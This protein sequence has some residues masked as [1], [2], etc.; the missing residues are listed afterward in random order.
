MLI[1]MQTVRL[2]SLDLRQVNVVAEKVEKGQWYAYF[3]IQNLLFLRTIGSFRGEGLVGE[4][5][6]LKGRKLILYYN[7]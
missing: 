4:T 6:I 2:I 3:P 1:G 5:R 7:F